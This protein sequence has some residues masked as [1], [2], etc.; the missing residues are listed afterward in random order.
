NRRGTSVFSGHMGEF[1]ASEL[2]TVV[3]D[4]TIAERRGSVAIDDEGTPGQYTVLIENGI[5]TGYMQ[6]TLPARLM[7]V[8]PTGHGRR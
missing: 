7:G 1:V 6:D 8:A 3:D 2:C 4:G 5:L